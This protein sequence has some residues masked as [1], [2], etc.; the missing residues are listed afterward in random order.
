M[1]PAACR[2]ELLTLSKSI[3]AVDAAFQAATDEA[4]AL[5]MMNPEA[6]DL[7]VQAMWELVEVSERLKARVTYA[8]SRMAAR[9]AREAEADQLEEAA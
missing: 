7:A 1:S 9:L 6:R 2:E 3:A 5:G 4:E 8:G